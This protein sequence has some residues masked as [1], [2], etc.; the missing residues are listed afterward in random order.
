[1]HSIDY[2]LKPIS[3][4]KLEQA[5]RKFREREMPGQSKE[6]ENGNQMQALLHALKGK[7]T[8]YKSRFMVRLGQRIMAI[9]IEQIAYFYSESKLTFIVS[10]DGRKFPIDTP[11]NEIE[12][13]L[14]PKSFFRIN[15]QFIVKFTAIAEMHPYFKGRI[16]LK[17]QPDCHEEIVVSSERSPEFKSWLEQ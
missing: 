17:L 10:E 11:L 13:L 3:K 14:E 6:W 15:R 8:Q 9:P 4:E 16:K 1:V 7:E 12:G 2:L 5:I